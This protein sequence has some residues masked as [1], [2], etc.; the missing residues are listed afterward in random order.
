MGGGGAA[1]ICKNLGV[2][3]N[4]TVEIEKTEIKPAKNVILAPINDVITVDKEFTDFVKNRLK[5]LPL[6]ENDEISTLF[7]RER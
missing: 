5:G 6:V 1:Y 2:S 7:F 4:D 3:L